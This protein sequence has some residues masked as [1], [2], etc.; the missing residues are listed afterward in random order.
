MSSKALSQL[1]ADLVAI[2]QSNMRICERPFNCSEFKSY[3]NQQ[4]YN[5]KLSL[6]VRAK[7]KNCSNRIPNSREKILENSTASSVLQSLLSL[8]TEYEWV[9]DI[10]LT[11][12]E[13]Y[14]RCSSFCF[15]FF[16]FRI[17]VRVP[18]IFLTSLNSNNCCKY[19]NFFVIKI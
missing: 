19:T 13:L 9:F 16:I 18:K 5:T 17:L 2:H 14:H 11:H 10:L 4:S 8:I 7:F 6:E 15:A 1:K 12:K 3:L